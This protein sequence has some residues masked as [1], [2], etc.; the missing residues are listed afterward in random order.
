MSPQSDPAGKVT[1]PALQAMKARGEKSV[2]IVAWDYQMARIADRVGV[3][4][5]SVGDTVGVN[6]WGQPHPLEITFDEVLVVA[7]AARRGV[8]RALLSCDFPFGPLQQ[9]A[10]SAVDASIRLVKE[11]GVDL[12]KLDGAADFPE[13]VEAVTR[14]GIPVFAQFGITPQTALKYGIE[15]SAAS[16]AQVPDGMLDELVAEAKRLESAGAVALNFTNSGPVV[17]PAVVD[18]VSIPVLG[19]FGGGPWLDGRIRMATAAI[20]YNAAN[21]DK[22]IDTYANV[23]R[24]T[25]DALTECAADI[26]GGRQIR[27]GI[28]VPQS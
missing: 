22:E 28:K 19:G 13:A 17:G 4:I 21:V 8:R 2:C 14:A 5:V 23:A 20:G 12:V 25:F 7:K 24:I 16:V 27:G 15:Y 6:L 11:A 1:I 26:R 3:D 18:A 9:G 10:A